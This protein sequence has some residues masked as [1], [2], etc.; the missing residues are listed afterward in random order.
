MCVALGV[1]VYN[2]SDVSD[3]TPLTSESDDF[4][5]N[6]SHVP[7]TRRPANLSDLDFVG[8]VLL[9]TSVAP[10]LVG[11][12]LAGSLYRWTDWQ[13]ISAIALGGISLLLLVGKELL[14]SSTPF[15]F[16]F[17]SKNA[18]HK[19]LLGLKLL[20]RRHGLITFGGAFWLGLLVGHRSP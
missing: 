11:L 3:R 15:S 14:P 7:D 4:T 20:Q 1:L 17:G 13:V 8:I 12:S 5:C 9:L 10:L 16:P 2:G 18:F 19:P 6:D